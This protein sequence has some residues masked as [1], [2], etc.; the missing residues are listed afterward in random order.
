[1]ALAGIVNQFGIGEERE[2][3]GGGVGRAV[4]RG[5]EAVQRD[6]PAAIEMGP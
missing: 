3:V 2:V 4:E 5:V 6:L 1:M